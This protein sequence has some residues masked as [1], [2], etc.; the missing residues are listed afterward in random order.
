MEAARKSLAKGR[1]KDGFLS[2]PTLSVFP[3][4]PS[5][6]SYLLSH[7]CLSFQIPEPNLWYGL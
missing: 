6:A 2:S 5:Y 7:S 3:K 4:S 1:G